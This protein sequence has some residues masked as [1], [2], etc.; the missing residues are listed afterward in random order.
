MLLSTLEDHFFHK[1]SCDRQVD[2]TDRYHTP[3]LFAVEGLKAVRL[4]GAKGMK[5]E[6]EEGGFLFLKLSL[7]LF[8]PEV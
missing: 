1:Q 4:L 8:L 3:G 2:G 5:Y 7:L 6:I